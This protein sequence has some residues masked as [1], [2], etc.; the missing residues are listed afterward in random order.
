MN[1]QEIAKKP[2]VVIGGKGGSGTRVFSEIVSELGCYQGPC[3]ASSDVVLWAE[4]IHKYQIPYLDKWWKNQI[5]SDYH[6]SM[7]KD[8][9]PYLKKYLEKNTQDLK[10]LW[11]NPQGMHILPFYHKFFPNMKFIHALRDGRDMV[12]SKN[13]NEFKQAAKT[14][15]WNSS[16]NENLIKKLNFWYHSNKLVK[17]Y[18]LKNMGNNY[19]S[20]KFED[21]CDYPRETIIKIANFIELPFDEEKIE[22]CIKL[23]KKPSSIG[24]WE[25]ASETQKERLNDFGEEGLRYFGYMTDTK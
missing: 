15:I 1:L 19:E 12:F 2:P 6:E 21:L 16:K 18:G 25:K 23:V 14:D 10:P 20:F 8:F 7:A 17:E 4:F 11:K 13:E 3:N 22:N 24:R 5:T 9:E